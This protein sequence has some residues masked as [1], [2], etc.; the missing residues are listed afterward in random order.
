MNIIAETA[1]DMC[2]FGQFVIKIIE[3]VNIIMVFMIQIWLL[4][5]NKK[6]IFSSG[7]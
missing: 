2:I 4:I 7:H 5:K 3:N 6:V 1:D